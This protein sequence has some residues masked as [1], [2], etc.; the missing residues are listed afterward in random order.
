MEQIIKLT[1]ENKEYTIS[2][3]EAI[4]SQKTEDKETLERFLKE[5]SKSSY[6]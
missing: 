2:L 5:L 3:F 4:Y 1:N 6:A